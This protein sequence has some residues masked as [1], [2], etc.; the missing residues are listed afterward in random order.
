MPDK[1]RVNP[2]GLS[3]RLDGAD[4]LLGSS[5]QFCQLALC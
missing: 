5:H 1:S 4:R 2:G 3:R